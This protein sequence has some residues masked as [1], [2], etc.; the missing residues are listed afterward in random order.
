MIPHVLHYCWFGGEVPAHL[1]ECMDSWPKAFPKE[2]WTILEWNESNCDLNCSEFVR[3]MAREKKWGFVSDWFRV[4]ALYEHGGIYL[5]TDVEVYKSFEDLFALP[6]FL[7][8]MYDSVVAT[9]VLGFEPHNPFLYELLRL[10]EHIKWVDPAACLSEIY[11][12][13]GERHICQ[14][15][16]MVFTH[17]ISCLYPDIRLDGK[18][19]VTN[20]FVI[21]PK[22]EFEIGKIIGRGH[23]VHRCDGSW[24]PSSKK[25]ERTKAILRLAKRTPLIHGDALLRR[26]S[27]TKWNFMRMRTL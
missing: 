1:R 3:V 12:P 4:Q 13:N 22:E 27:H 21:F 17:L 23:C 19:H 8:Y 18:R 26:V 24:I 16:N 6:G 25:R 14:N 10:Y 9:A 15:N 2:R 20:D 5:D 11:L 7:G